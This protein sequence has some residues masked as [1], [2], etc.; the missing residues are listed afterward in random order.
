MLQLRDSLHGV[1]LITGPCRHMLAWASSIQTSVTERVRGTSSSVIYLRQLSRGFAGKSELHREKNQTSE[2]SGS[3]PRSRPRTWEMGRE[4]SGGHVTARHVWPS[5]N[6]DPPNSHRSKQQIK[7]GSRWR[8]TATRGK[9]TQQFGA[10]HHRHGRWAVWL[11]KRSVNTLQR[12]QM[13]FPFL[14]L[15]TR[16]NEPPPLPTP[17]GGGDL[18]NAWKQTGSTVAQPLIPRLFFCGAVTSNPGRVVQVIHVTQNRNL[19]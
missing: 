7:S 12:L 2:R 5:A 13:T 1:S 19:C 16:V 10:K 3:P 15:C 8:A 14:R 17:G 4:E 6:E 11:G 18:H 9:Q